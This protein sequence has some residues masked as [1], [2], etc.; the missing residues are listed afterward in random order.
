I[1]VSA[2]IW[3]LTT[4]FRYM[5]GSIEDKKLWAEISYL[6][7]AF[8]PVCYFL[9]TT[10]YSQKT[11]NITTRKVLLLITIPLITIPLVFTNDYHELIWQ[12]VQEVSSIA[13]PIIPDYGNW[14]WIFWVYC[15]FLI[16]AGLYNL[17]VSIS[18]FTSYYKSQIIILLIATLIPMTGNIIYITNLN[19]I[20]GFDWTPVLFVFT[21]L[22]ISYGIKRYRMFNL[23]PFARDTLIN[24]MSDG[25]I[26]LNTDEII[27][28]SNPAIENIFKFDEPVKHK[29][30]STVFKKY[31]SFVNAVVKGKNTLLEIDSINNERRRIYQVR[32]KPIYNR[33]KQFSGY[34]I[35]LNNVTSLKNTENSFKQVNLKLE[36]EVEERGRLIEDL[37]SFAHTVAHDLKKSLGSIYNVAE[38]IEECIKTGNSEMLSEFSGDIKSSAMRAI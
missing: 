3:A 9:F 24:T 8:L 29:K 13:E 36:A 12:N 16:I 18:K 21:G 14:F 7:I 37:K 34:L 6:G 1:E 17:V 30:F 28:D 32:V 31:D 11:K 10:A 22:M 35:Q 38:I 26:I 23:V 15:Y 33:Y 5:A 19:P 20:P 27:E 25:I 2:A 4:G